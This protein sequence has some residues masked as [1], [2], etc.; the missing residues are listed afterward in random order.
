LE[1]AGGGRPSVATAIASF[2]DRHPDFSLPQSDPAALRFGHAKHLVKPILTTEGRRVQLVCSDCHKVDKDGGLTAMRPVEYETA[3]ARCHPLTF[4]PRLADEQA[5]HGEALRVREFLLRVYL[6]RQDVLS[7]GELRRRLL[8]NPRSLP[9]IDLSR[10]ANEAVL[11]A[12]RYLYGIAC[13]KCH[14]VDMEAARVPAV[15]PPHIP[16][17]WLARSKPFPHD[18]HQ[19]GLACADCHDRAA[20]SVVTSDV[21]IPGIAACAGCHGGD[22]EPPGEA[23]RR[24]GPHDCRSCHGYHPQ[25]PSTST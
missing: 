16:P 8:R 15:A 2:P 25:T 10:R 1:I 13:Q 12:E 23:K 21:L 18:R 9:P 6:Y 20:A 24:P 14:T 11:D 17:R 5:P 7:I 22:A 3:C 19:T 4:D